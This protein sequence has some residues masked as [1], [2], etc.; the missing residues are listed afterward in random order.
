MHYFYATLYYDMLISIMIY[1]SLILELIPSDT[2]AAAPLVVHVRTAPTVKGGI[3]TGQLWPI[4]CL[5][6]QQARC[7]EARKR[8]AALTIVHF[9]I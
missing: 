3:G 8:S 7:V 6:A 1:V 9:R 5:S 2:L 4:C